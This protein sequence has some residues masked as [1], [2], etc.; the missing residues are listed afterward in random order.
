MTKSFKELLGNV[1]AFAFDVDGVL[2]TS[3]TFIQP[4]GQLFRTANIKDGYSIQLLRKKGYPVAIITGGNYEGVRKRFE[5]LGVTDIY[6][7]A[8]DKRKALDDFV[9]KHHLDIQQ[10]M[11]MGDDIPDLP[12]MKLVGVPVCPADAA[13]DIKAV[14]RYISD[15]NGGEGCVRDVVEQVLRARQDWLTENDH[16]W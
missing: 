10:I 9:K 1:T 4:D 14:A 3:I 6:F 16:I 8:N 15:K 5:N 11:Y 7:V 13:E 12:P 2:S